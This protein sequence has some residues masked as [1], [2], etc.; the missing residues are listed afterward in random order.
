[1]KT[2]VSVTVTIAMFFLMLLPSY[3][4]TGIQNEEKGAPLSVIVSL[5]G[6][7]GHVLVALHNKDTFLKKPLKSEVATIVNGKAFVTFNNIKPGTYAIV[8]LHD[9]NDNKIMDFDTYGMPLEAYGI[10]NNV[11]LMGP[12]QWED[13]NF[14][15][16][17]TPL[18]LEISI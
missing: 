3:G 15:M 4:Q 13:A 11:L 12:P 14:E 2:L 8:V 7:G 18:Q 5:R 16:G 1:M 6:Q 10:S 9:K 17:N